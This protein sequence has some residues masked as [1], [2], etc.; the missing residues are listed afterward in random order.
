MHQYRPLYNA[1]CRTRAEHVVTKSPKALNELW[2]FIVRLTS[3]PFPPAGESAISRALTLCIARRHT[4]E[5][6][7]A[8]SPCR[9]EIIAYP[10]PI[11]EYH[12]TADALLRVDRSGFAV[13][14]MN[15]TLYAMAGDPLFRDPLRERTR[16]LL[17]ARRRISRDYSR[18]T[19][20]EMSR[21]LRRKYV[22]ATHGAR[23]LRRGFERSVRS[24]GPRHHSRGKDILREIARKA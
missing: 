23:N 7:R 19:S 24:F 17:P 4:R 21:I 3:V 18:E 12:G 14:R 9:I 2:N 13:H 5:D 15:G 1:L 6:P 10:Y 20:A 8:G 16:I 22:A 11:A